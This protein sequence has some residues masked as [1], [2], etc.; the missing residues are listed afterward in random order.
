MNKN[1]SSNPRVC[2]RCNKL[3]T[4]NSN[5]QEYCVVCQK[6][7]DAERCKRRH[8]RVYIKK[9]YSQKR[10][11]NNNWKKGIGIYRT[12]IV[13]EHCEWCKVTTDLLVHHKDHDRTNN[14]LDNLI[15]VCKRCHQ[16][17]HVK[18]DPITGRFISHH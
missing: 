4:P 14:T 13:K 12:L 15:V 5:R 10:E 11:C 18:R 9:G 3:Y 7:L 17:H 2:K 6:E 16:L 8:T 1:V